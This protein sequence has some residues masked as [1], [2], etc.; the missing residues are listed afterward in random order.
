M[1]SLRR[2]LLVCLTV[3]SLTLASLP[4]TPRASALT[5]TVP[6]G[7]VAAL[8]QAINDANSTQ[9]ADEIVLAANATYTLTTEDNDSNGLPIIT[10]EITITGNGAT[11]TRDAGAPEFRILEIGDG[12]SLTIDS[13]TISNGVA[14][15]GGGI[16]VDSASLTMINST[17][18]G[19][20]SFY[21]GAIYNDVGSLTL[22]NST[23]NGNISNDDGGGIYTWRGTMTLT[24]STVSDNHVPADGGGIYNNSTAT[25][26]TNSTISLNGAEDGGGI[27][28][29]AGLV[30]LMNTIVAGN[31]SSDD[32]PDIDGPLTTDSSYNLIGNGLDVI[33]VADGVNGNQVGTNQNP[34]DP[35]LGQLQDN[36]GPTQTMALL[37]GSP[38]IN[39]GND[40]VAP[41]TDQRGIA[42]PQGAASDIGAYEVEG[43]AESPYVELCE[44][45]QSVVRNASVARSACLTL[46]IAE[47]A[48]AS[49]NVTLEQ[50]AL[51]NY[52]VQIRSAISRR[53]VSTRDGQMLI[54][55]ARAI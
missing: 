24:N 6:D 32:G 9:G 11:I 25:T 2:M 8:I 36:G 43:E 47:Q 45:T 30:T 21:G 52:E 18:T 10:S 40:A 42:R 39:A 49:G 28:Y 37:D 55:M 22:I 51:L 53:Y 20:T 33:G 4:S 46:M 27:F 35:R 50:I 13:V 26:I 5:I 23:L 7:D 17:V 15:E 1:V 16:Y 44:L 14:Y 19:S 12:G 38:A 31:T 54:T 48:V 34:I 29:E 3:V 41:A